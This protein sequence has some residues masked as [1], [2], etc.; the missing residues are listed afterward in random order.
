MLYPKE[1]KENRFLL[2]VCWSCSYQQEVDS[3]CVFVNKITQ[4]W[5]R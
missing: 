2:K 5:T 4:R 1:E 3:R